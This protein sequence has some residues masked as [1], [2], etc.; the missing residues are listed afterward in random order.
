[1]R[2]RPDVVRIVHLQGGL[3]AVDVG[4]DQIFVQVHGKKRFLHFPTP[5]YA[6]L[7]ATLKSLGFHV[8]GVEFVSGRPFDAPDWWF[9]PPEGQFRLT[10]LS[11]A[12]GEMRHLAHKEKKLDIVDISRRCTALL[13]LLGLRMLQM[14]NAYNGTYLA[15]ASSCNLSD[16]DLFDNMYTRHIEAAI[17]AFLTDAASLRD[18]ICEFVWAYV[19]HEQ[20]EL[21]S[22]K[23]FR[24]RAKA[25]NHPIATAI[26]NAGEGGWIKRLSQLRNDVIHVAPIGA[27]HSFPPCHTRRVILPD[28]GVVRY[29]SYGLVDRTSVASSANDDFRT[30]DE[31]R[32]KAELQ[33]Y[34]AQLDSSDDALQYCWSVLGDL[35]TLCEAARVAS[36]LKGEIPSIGP[37]DIV[38]FTIAR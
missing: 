12:W 32:I 6:R 7:Y 31:E 24:T 37:E 34:K 19:L 30:K 23:T 13:E 11:R 2:D 8:I 26:I 36:G 25:T 17:H 9:A 15:Q 16:E 22:F 18:L 1:M 29:V 27:H 28:G 38:S 14:S 5:E 10:Q 33:I 35:L 20:S 4:S 21:R 3:R